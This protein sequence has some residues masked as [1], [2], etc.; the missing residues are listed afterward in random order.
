MNL[1]AP[2]TLR[3]PA[4]PGAT[5]LLPAASICTP[6]HRDPVRSCVPHLS[7][8]GAAQS[9]GNCYLN[10]AQLNAGLYSL[11]ATYG[12]DPNFMGSSSTPQAFT[13]DQVTTRMQVFPVPG[14]A[15]YG[16]ENGN[17]FI[18]GAGG[19]NG[20]N[21][22]GFFSITANGVNLVAPDSCSAQN[23]GA[24]PCYIDS[25]TALPASTA[26]YTVTIS[27]PGDVN[28]TPASTTVPLSVFP[29]TTS[30][31]LT[32]SPS[33]V[34][35]G[36]EGSVNISA[37][38]TS[39]TSGAPSGP[40]A[41]KNGGSTVCTINHLSQVGPNVST[42]SCP[43]LSDTELT[44][45]TYSLTADFPGDGNFQSSVSSAQQ[46]TIN[47]QGYWEVS[48]D[49]GL[50]SFGA[51]QFFGST[52]GMPLNSPVVGMAST[53]DGGGYWLVARDGG[54]FAYGNAHFYGS[55]GG[56]AL[57]APIVGMVATPDGQ[58]YWE[59]ASDGGAFAFGDAHFYGSMGGRH[60]N[61]PIVGIAATTDGLGYWE[62]AS[63]GGLFSFGDAA[64]KGSM[65]GHHLNEPIVGMAADPATGGYWEVATDGGLFSFDATFAGSAGGMPLNQPVVGMASTPDGQGYWEV[66]SD[67]GVFTF[68][69]AAFNGSA[70]NISLAPIVGIAASV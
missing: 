36:S 28:F 49:G 66:A 63:D 42:G 41:V 6:A 14:Y 32:V 60:L 38:V 52:G 43:P 37:T 45:G 58:G 22:T 7:T 1:K 11:T 33:T 8:E 39:G 46:L 31:T 2:W 51:A 16:A 40:V 12:G 67:G 21:P 55:M 5:C 26:P 9:S 15:F 17:F 34:T 3:S 13:I 57:D 20:G 25:A 50:F 61:E 53:P 47:V 65:G 44:A 56:Q 69:D 48:S 62:V 18:V 4:P 10:N 27:Y 35:Y 70:A 59:V 30:T 64:F 54:V 68:G 23:G 29:A 19:G 24:N